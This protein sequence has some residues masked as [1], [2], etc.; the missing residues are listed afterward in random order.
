MIEGNILIFIPNLSHLV[1][2]DAIRNPQYTK[3][4]KTYRGT[5]YKGADLPPAVL[6]ALGVVITYVPTPIAIL[7]RGT[8]IGMRP[9]GSLRISGLFT[10]YR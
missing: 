1:P 2:R 3:K 4:P 7:R 10:T 6:S 5:V 9:V 8:A